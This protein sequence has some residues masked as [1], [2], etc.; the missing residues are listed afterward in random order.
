MGTQPGSCCLPHSEPSAHKCP[1]TTCGSKRSQ[2]ALTNRQSQV[3]VAFHTHTLYL[4]YAQPSE[5]APSGRDQAPKT[6][7]SPAWGCGPTQPVE[8]PT[9]P[10]PYHPRSKASQLGL[11]FRVQKPHSPLPPKP[12]C[13]LHAPP[14]MPGLQLPLAG[15]PPSWRCTAW[16]PLSF[17]PLLQPE[18]MPGRLVTDGN[19]QGNRG[20]S[21]P[22]P[23]S[24]WA[25]EL[26]AICAWDKGSKLVERWKRRVQ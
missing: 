17:S 26:P 14:P 12:A 7:D 3:A 4:S 13:R 23:K 21:I 22:V 11:C 16:A 6:G 19:R 10:P 5:R 24:N 15:A 8:M 18:H 25:A 9:R 2:R 20:H 1:C